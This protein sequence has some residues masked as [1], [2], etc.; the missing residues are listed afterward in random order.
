MSIQR[1]NPVNTIISAMREVFKKRRFIGIGLASAASIGVSIIWLSSHKLIWFA[2]TSDIF[3]WSAK[4][5]ILW[6]SLGLFAT[7]FTLASQIMIVVV[8][9]LSGINIA[10]LVFYFKRRMVA[11]GA[12]SASG[13]GLVIGTLGVG[14]SVCG[15]VVL[16]SLIGITSA[17][18]LI[19]VLPLRGVEFGLSS[20]ALIGLSTYWLAKKIALPEICEVKPRA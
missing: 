13:F 9:L 20:I 19:S 12:A 7:N 11:K 14:C 10:M 17:S 2:L 8:V 15:S 16:S 18:A 6:T 1:Y 3:N 4:L 5:K